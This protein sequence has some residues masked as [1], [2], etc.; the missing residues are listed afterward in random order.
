LL[1]DENV[2]RLLTCMGNSNETDDLVYLDGMKKLR[3]SKLFLRED[4]QDHDLLY[5]ACET[6]ALMRF[7]FL[8]DWCP[9]GLKTHKYRGPLSSMQE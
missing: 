6:Y 1:G 5:L 2:L 8:A 7:E 4:I 9:E 3:K